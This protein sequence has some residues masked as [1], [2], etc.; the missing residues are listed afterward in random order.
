MAKKIIYSAGA[1][2]IVALLTSIYFQLDEEVKIHI[3]K[4]RTI[5][6]VWDGNSFEPTAYEYTRIF[7]GTKLMRAKNRTLD[8]DIINK[9][10]WTY[11]YKNITTAVDANNNT[12]SYITT[13]TSYYI[14]NIK[15]EITRTASFKEKIIAEDTYTFDGSIANVNLIPKSHEVCFTNA[16][17]KIFEYLIR[18]TANTYDST[19]EITSPFSF[20]E[21]MQVE[22]EDDYYRAK[23]YHYK[24]VDDKIKVRYRI[25]NDSQCFDVRLYDPVFGAD[26]YFK[27]DNRSAEESSA[28]L[29]ANGTPISQVGKL[30][31]ST[32][33]NATEWEWLNS[34]NDDDFTP[35]YTSNLT[36]NYWV[37]P[38]SEPNIDQ[39]NHG[40]V[41]INWKSTDFLVALRQ[42][43]N[44]I[45]FNGKL[46]NNEKFTVTSNA[47]IRQDSWSM[48]TL[49]LNGSHALIYINGTLNNT[50]A[51]F[52]GGDWSNLT[53]IIVGKHR[54]GSTRSN[55][56]FLNGSIDD[57]SISA[58]V[59][60]QSWIDARWNDGDG[61]ELSQLPSSMNITMITP[62]NNT[63]H[64]NPINV[65]YNASS[66]FDISNCSLIINGIVNAT[67]TSITKNL[68]WQNFS[69]TLTNATYNWNVTCTDDR[70]I[71][72]NGTQNSFILIVNQSHFS[73]S[74]N[75]SIHPRLNDIFYPINYSKL[76]WSNI[77]T[78]TTIN[79]GNYTWNLTQ[80]AVPTFNSTT[81]LFNL[82]NLGTVRLNITLRKN[83][84]QSWYTWN[85]TNTTNT[86]NI[87]QEQIQLFVLKPSESKVINCTLDMLNISQTH[88]NWTLDNASKRS[89]WTIDYVF[90]WTEV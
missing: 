18:D 81:F 25:I 55:H 54:M 31:N 78:N 83:T 43:S 33:F 1:I 56:F 8:Y 23:Y 73:T 12:I 53:T 21:K 58:G 37:Y 61:A 52:S 86:F 82:T 51:M 66:F 26:I 11:T 28:F 49:I 69:I 24:T 88:I 87:T 15:T 39:G 67:D 27:L 2:I 48:I 68:P 35:T 63:N 38:L 45:I 14:E 9:S 5:F 47:E 59:R 76:N 42:D 70:G 17:G 20:G 29:V 41:S 64:S 74:F 3:Y 62:L 36:M 34:S 44:K 30:G 13:N 7:D 4:T 65:T 40:L 19:F 77:F 89:N 84:T 71:Q 80:Y 85:C 75:W 10:Y 79:S 32:W 60:P 46:N 6:S 50:A 72:F 90:N 22:F 57:L 16:Q